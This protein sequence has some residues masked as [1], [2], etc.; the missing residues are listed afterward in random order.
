MSVPV[1]PCVPLALDTAAGDGQETARMFVCS[2]AHPLDCSH[3][4]TDTALHAET[5]LCVSCVVS[6][7]PAACVPGVA[8]TGRVLQSTAR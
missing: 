3:T 4:H 6:R 2:S 5:V 1:C 7:L 8:V